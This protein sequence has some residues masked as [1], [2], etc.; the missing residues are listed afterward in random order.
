LE[1]VIRHGLLTGYFDLFAY[2]HCPIGVVAA[3]HYHHV[4]SL[5]SLTRILLPTL[6]LVLDGPVLKTEWSVVVLRLPKQ[7][8]SQVIIVVI[9]KTDVDPSLLWGSSHFA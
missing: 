6:G 8:P 4:T 3:D 5:D 2:T 1:K 9:V 7:H